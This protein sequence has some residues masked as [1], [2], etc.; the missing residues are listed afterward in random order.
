MWRK[1]IVETKGMNSF[2]IL[3]EKFKIGEGAVSKK[4]R[5]KVIERFLFANAEPGILG[6]NFETKAAVKVVGKK[7]IVGGNSASVL[8]NSQKKPKI[9]FLKAESHPGSTKEQSA[10]FKTS[11]SKL[12]QLQCPPPPVLKP[13]AQFINEN[14]P[15][16]YFTPTK[17]IMQ[18]L[19]R[20]A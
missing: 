6:L 12:C 16:L 9:E 20:K 8:L 10:V 11:I 18:I 1:V 13:L 4:A 2:K 15:I 3:G 19:I 5:V 7:Q 17:E 14:P